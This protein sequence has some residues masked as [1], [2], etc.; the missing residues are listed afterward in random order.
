VSEDGDV[1]LVPHLKPRVRGQTIDDAVTLLESA[2]GDGR[3][4]A[5]SEAY[6][7]VKDLAFYL[8]PAQVERVNDLAEAE[9]KLALTDGAIAIV[10]PELKP[11]PELNDSYFVE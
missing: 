9:H 10:R 4:A 7:R 11:D 3:P 6:D 5:F 1:T 8:S 2:A